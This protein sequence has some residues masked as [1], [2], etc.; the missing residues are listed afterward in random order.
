VTSLYWLPLLLLAACPLMHVFGHGG[1]GGHGGHE[2]NKDEVA[3][4]SPATPDAP[5]TSPGRSHSHGGDLP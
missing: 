2:R 5:T 1:H 3:G 4:Q